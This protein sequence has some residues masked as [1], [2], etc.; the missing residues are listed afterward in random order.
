MGVEVA[1]EMEMAAGFVGATWSSLV[2]RASPRLKAVSAVKEG[3]MR[4][5]SCACMA[6]S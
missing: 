6:L 4:A 1:R 2:R 3:K 5:D